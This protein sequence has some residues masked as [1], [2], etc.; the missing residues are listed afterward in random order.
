LLFTKGFE[1][2][3]IKE[4]RDMVRMSSGAFHH[5]FESRSTLLDALIERMQ[6]EVE[7]PL[8]PI[9][10]DPQL[11]ATQKLQGFFDTL[12]QLRA[13]HQA[14][15]VAL[16][17]VWY[18]DANAMVR[19]KVDEAVHEQRMPLL[20]AIIDQGLREGR[21]RTAHAARAADIVLALLQGMSNAHARTLLQFDQDHDAERCI[22]AIVSSHDG[23]MDAVERVLGAP[24]NSF[25]RASAEAVIVWVTAMRRDRPQ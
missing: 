4:I 17:R 24:A 5:Y 3:S 20:T 23:Y 9:L 19:L 13:D 18:S 14:D 15:V 8:L 21:F 16:L 2:V 11:S 25:V 7:Q 12:S 6:H 10:H 1:Q 22:S